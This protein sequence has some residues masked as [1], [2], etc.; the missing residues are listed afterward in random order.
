MRALATQMNTP[1][2]AKAMELGAL[3]E[4]GAQIDAWRQRCHAKRSK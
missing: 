3:A 1:D 4:V 2:V